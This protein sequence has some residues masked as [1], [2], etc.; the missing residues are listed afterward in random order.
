MRGMTFQTL[1]D[2]VQGVV[3]N[4]VL[5]IVFL[6]PAFLL[7]F[8]FDAMLGGVTLDLRSP[9]P[10]RH[11]GARAAADIAPGPGHPCRPAGGRPAV[12]ARQ[13]HL[14][15]ARSAAR[16][17]RRS[18]PG[19]GTTASRSGRSWKSA[20]SRSTSGHWAPPCPSWPERCCSWPPRCRIGRPS[21]SE[22]SSSSTPCSWSSRPRSPAWARRSARSP[23]SCRHWSRSGPSLPKPLESG[24]R[25]E[26]RSSTWAARSGFDHVSFRYH[27]DGPLILDDVSIHAHPGEFVAIAGESGAGKST[28]FRLALGLE[29]P[30]AGAVYY[31]GRDLGAPQRQAGAPQDRHG[32]AGRAAPSAG[33]AGTTSSRSTT[34]RP[35][36]KRGRRPGS[37]PWTPRSGRCR[38]GC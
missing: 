26:N 28:L 21:R 38:W 5:S 1:R 2:A 27:P 25:A 17:G 34:T 32:A 4:A 24:R 36:T 30:S 13:R 35:S 16:R 18:R 8:F 20:P 37:R 9:V 33:P 23:R 22:T 11:G 7:I 19:P 29:R 31:D 6:S 12:P 10:G 3:A 15:A 14:Q